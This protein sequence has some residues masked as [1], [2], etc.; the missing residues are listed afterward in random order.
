VTGPAQGLRWNNGLG[1]Y[2]EAPSGG[3]ASPYQVG[4]NGV[5]F[6]SNVELAF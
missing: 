2:D 4:A 3:L 5:I 1:Y 6:Q